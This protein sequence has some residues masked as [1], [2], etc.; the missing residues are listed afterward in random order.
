[1]IKIAV[2][3]ADPFRGRMGSTFTERQGK[4]FVTTVQPGSPAARVGFQPGDQVLSIAGQPVSGDVKEAAALMH[5]NPG[6]EVPVVLQTSGR[7]PRQVQIR[8][9]VP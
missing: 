4:L 5:A 7:A 3:L 6:V 9:T 8:R 1:M 2:D